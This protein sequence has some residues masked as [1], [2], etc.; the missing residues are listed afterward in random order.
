MEGTIVMDGVRSDG[1]DIPQTPSFQHDGFPIL[2]RRVWMSVGT[3]SSRVNNLW[4]A[5]IWLKHNVQYG[6]NQGSSV[7]TGLA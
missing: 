7:N 2:V 6:L 1:Q 5:P 4:L 3:I